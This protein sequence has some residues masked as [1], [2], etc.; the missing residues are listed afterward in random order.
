MNRSPPMRSLCRVICGCGR[1]R[2]MYD[3]RVTLKCID[4]YECMIIVG[5]QPHHKT[6][7]LHISSENVFAACGVLA[8]RGSLHTPLSR[9]ETGGA[10]GRP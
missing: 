1:R 6:R 5:R 9:Q 3:L 8:A 7:S 2:C 10:E 4:D